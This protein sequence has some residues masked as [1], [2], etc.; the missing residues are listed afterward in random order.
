MAVVGVLRMVLRIIFGLNK[1]EV[2]IG[3]RKLCSDELQNLYTS[4]DIIRMIESGHIWR[5]GKV[6]LV[7][8]TIKA[9]KSLVRKLKGRDYLEDLGIDG[10]ILLKHLKETK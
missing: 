3:W 10:R 7:E 2:T 4:S 6:A 1:D 9:F 5:I 8:R